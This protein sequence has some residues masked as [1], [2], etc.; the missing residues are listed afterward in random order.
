MIHVTDD[1]FV[2]K[3]NGLLEFL[4]FSITTPGWKKMIDFQE[5]SLYVS[6]GKLACPSYG[7]KVHA[8]ADGTHAVMH[9]SSYGCPRGLRRGR[10]IK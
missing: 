7:C 6:P 5:V 1:T 4:V 9:N 8:H 10:T 3:N 2:R